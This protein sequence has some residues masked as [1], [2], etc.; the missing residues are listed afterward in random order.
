MGLRQKAAKVI[1]W[2]VIQKWGRTAVWSLSLIILSRLLAPEA[3][4]LVALATAFIAFIE[5]FLDM[6]FGAAI[7]QR[8]DLEPGHLDTAFWISVSIGT[9]LTFV[10]IAASGLLAGLF[11]EPRLA[12]V[13]SWLSIGFVLIGLSAIQRAI[14]QRNLAFKNLAGRSLTATVVSGIVGIS[15]AFAG[16]GVWSLVSQNLARSL[17]GVVVLWRASS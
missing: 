2:S 12:P 17:A 10:T 9:L 13:L 15:M 16:Y 3:F 4:G 7:V 14:L 5:I 11:D 8:T 6:G 1:F